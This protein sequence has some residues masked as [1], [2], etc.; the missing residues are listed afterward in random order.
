MS[1]FFM[2]E[3]GGGI[4]VVGFVQCRRGIFEGSLGE[5][6]GDGKVGGCRTTMYGCVMLLAWLWT[7]EWMDG[8]MRRLFYWGLGGFGLVVCH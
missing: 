8:W 2:G 5:R 6:R 1:F 4:H 7:N 3:R